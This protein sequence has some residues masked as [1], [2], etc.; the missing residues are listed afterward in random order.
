MSQRCLSCQ[1]GWHRACVGDTCACEHLAYHYI[2]VTSVRS[3]RNAERFVNAFAYGR[4]VS[5][6]PPLIVESPL[7]EGEGYTIM[8]PEND[9]EIGI[10]AHDEARQKLLVCL[11]CPQESH[12]IIRLADSQDLPFT[13]CSDHWEELYDPSTYEIWGHPG[14][15][16]V[17]LGY[18]AEHGWATQN[19]PEGVRHPSVPTDEEWAKL[20][21][22]PLP[23]PDLD[24]DEVMVKLKRM[25][26]GKV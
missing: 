7:E 20:H 19:H 25:L 10:H 21:P 3:A 2:G 24:A 11:H 13:V 15:N 22:E 18:F 5:H 1:H 4:R 9:A 17:W 12:A 14:S 6:L 8:K 23:L 26:K 16:T